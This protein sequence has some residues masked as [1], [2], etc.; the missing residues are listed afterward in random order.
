MAAP[1]VPP[2]A[3]GSIACRCRST[4]R[5]TAFG[6]SANPPPDQFLVALAALSLMEATW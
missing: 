3:G 5:G 1:V 2:L 6:I 4:M